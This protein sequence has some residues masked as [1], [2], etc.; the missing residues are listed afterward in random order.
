MAAAAEQVLSDPALA[1]RLRA[2]GRAEAERYTWSAVKPVLFDAYARA[3]GRA[4]ADA[5]AGDPREQSAGRGG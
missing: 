1:E 5:A 4:I 2:A 3:L